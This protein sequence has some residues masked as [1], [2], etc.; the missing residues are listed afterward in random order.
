[1]TD[2]TLFLAGLLTAIASGASGQSP[3]VGPTDSLPTPTGPYAVG[4]R[5]YS[6]IDTARPELY[7][8]APG[9]H[10]QVLVQIWY[11][12]EPGTGATPA[13]YLVNPATVR[14][15]TVAKAGAARRSHSFLDAPV[16]DAARRYPVLLYNHGGGWARWSA[17]FTTEAMAS[18]GY[19]VVSVEHP[20][21]SQTGG[22]LDGTRFEPDTLGFPTPGGDL[23]TDALA[24]WAY[25][26]DPVFRFWVADARFVLDRLERLDEAPGPFQGRLDL[27]RIG[28]FGWSFG[29][30]TAVE[31]TRVDPRVKVAV[32]QDGQLFG[33]V[34]KGTERP[35]LLMHHG[36]DD[37][38][39]L[40][41][42]QRPAMRKLIEQ[43]RRGDSTVRA[44][45]T[46][47]WYELTVDGTQ[48]GHFSDLIAF[49]PRGATQLDPDTGFAIINAYTLAFF[50]HYLLG[51]PAELLTAESPPFPAAT[52]RVWRR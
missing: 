22:F 19:V 11:P 52:L 27:S 10:R 35:V 7:T 41:E 31:L 51:K 47:P 38:L 20:G 21:F 48:H 9:D 36:L 15:T 29:G 30:A 40:P 28:A 16:A 44:N 13:P 1:M 12:A 32:D 33:E 18:H 5:D 2:R 6:W 24:G 4:T 37:A 17:S 46:G 49:Y 42:A 23:E 14:D 39:G 43:V 8:T 25:L 45:S 50:D 26:E 34:R 3:P